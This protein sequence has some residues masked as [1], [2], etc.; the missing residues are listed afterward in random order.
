MSYEKND[1]LVRNGVIN[2]EI[3]AFLFLGNRGLEGHGWRLV[4]CSTC[5][6]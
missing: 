4:Y 1:L 6:I 5:P 2:R 3:E